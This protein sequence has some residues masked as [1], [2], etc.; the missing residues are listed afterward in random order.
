VELRFDRSPVRFLINKP[1]Q[2]QNLGG[3]EAVW[4][5]ES[6][7]LTLLRTS[8]SGGYKTEIVFLAARLELRAK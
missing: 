3:G 4:L 1:R 8:R 2:I 7:T 5:F 6:V